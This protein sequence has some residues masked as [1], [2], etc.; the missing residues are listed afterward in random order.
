MI[1]SERVFK[2]AR[3]DED[4]G[5]MGMINTHVPGLLIGYYNFI[6]VQTCLDNRR[7]CSRIEAIYS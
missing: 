2:W 6:Y 1:I 5:G 7:P 3:K 4:A